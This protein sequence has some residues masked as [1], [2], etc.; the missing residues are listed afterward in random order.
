VPPYVVAELA[1]RI[2]RCVPGPDDRGRPPTPA[3]MLAAARQVE[4]DAYEVECAT[5]TALTALEA[6]DGDLDGWTVTNQPRVGPSGQC[7]GSELRA[8][9][10]VSR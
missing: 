8:V 7:A 5:L 6:L 10:W 3:A 1:V 4:S 9:V 2:V